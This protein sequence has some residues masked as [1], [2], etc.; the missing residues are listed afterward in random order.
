MFGICSKRGVRL[1]HSLRWDTGLWWGD[2]SS[3]SHRSLPSCSMLWPSSNIRMLF[4]KETSSQDILEHPEHLNLWQ[5]N[6][7]AKQGQNMTKIPSSAIFGPFTDSEVNK[8]KL[9]NPVSHLSSG[10]FPL[11]RTPVVGS[12]PNTY[13]AIGFCEGDS[14][15]IWCSL[16]IKGLERFRLRLK[17]KTSAGLNKETNH[18]SLWVHQEL[19]SLELLDP[20]LATFV[21]PESV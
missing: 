17:S 11:T 16:K 7:E 19:L 10:G 13:V 4:F 21:V 14:V 12:S 20:H 18:N 9:H 15:T 5:A 2:H 3:Y 1:S 8:S 6:R